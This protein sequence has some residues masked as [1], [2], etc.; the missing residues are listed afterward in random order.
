MSQAEKS[1]KPVI[2]AQIMGK[3]IGGGVESVI[4][5]YYRHLD[6]TKVQFDF[7]CDEDSTRIP[8]DEIKK[9]G[10]RVF[11]VPKYQKLPQYLKALEGL[12]RK[13]QYR[14]VHS[15]VNT[16]SVFPLYAAKKAGVPVRISHSHST[17]NPKEWKRNIIKN[18]L[19]P[20]SKKYATDYF[21]CSELAGRYLFGDKTFDQGKVKIIHNAIDL[22]KF[23]FDPEARKKLRKELG[24]DDKTIVIGHVGRFVKQKNHDFLVDVFN[25]YHT[26]NPD[27]KLLL[28]GTGPLEEKIKAKVKKLDL[29]D[30][31][32]FLGQR[33]DTNKLYSVMDVFCLPSLYEGLPVV[34]VEA[35]AAGLLCELSSDMTKETKVLNATRFISLEKPS[36][37]WAKTILEDYNS[38][39]RHDITEEIIKN[40]YNIKKEVSKLENKYNKLLKGRSMVK[41]ITITNAY[42]WYNKGDAGILLATIDTLKKIYKDAEF[43][44]LSFTPEIDRKH[45]C[46]DKTVK[47][48]YSNILNPHPYKKGKLGK[49][50][51]V[52]K[53]FSKMIE[54]QFGLT[55]FKKKTIEK[56]ES[57]KAL[58]ESDIIIVCGGGF[59]GGKKFDSLMHVYQIYV[60]TIFKKPVYIMGTSIEPIKKKLIKHYTDKV[61]N[62]VDF[63]FAREKIT[64]KYLLETLPDEKH[65]LIPDMAFMLEDI[66]RKFDF[67]EKLRKKNDVLFGITVRKWNFPNLKD[68]NK[69][70]ENYISCIKDF[71]EKEFNIRSC[72]FVFI[73]QV[74]VNTGDDT[75][76]AEEIRNRL[77]KKNQDKFYIC[78]E[79]L[80]PSEIKSL[81]ANMDYF[82]GTR[83][84]SNIFATSMCVPTTAIAYEKKTNGIMETVGLEEYIIEINDITSDDL[85]SKVE[86][87]ISNAKIIKKQL[88]NKIGAARKDVFLK[89]K[90]VVK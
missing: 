70:M 75:I 58:Q 45:Y 52:I 44:I 87:M 14:I 9:L 88:K 38:F 54:I 39:K 6:H 24:I 42:T 60:N 2:V 72:A 36:E 55:F 66:E 1:K 15:N 21:A 47:N 69:S 57:L 7:I 80:S 64:E 85:F 65:T 53:L 3:W 37:E 22:D 78:R 83:M 81:I 46:E 17:S 19:R 27:S 12:F 11:L 67:V 89:I 48:V 49:I 35:Q 4:M 79:D 82:V 41:K 26:K 29:S 25:E 33:E 43:N 31:V 34:G 71:M 63:V 20:F 8:Y 5:N 32:L 30:S 28:I 10:G 62:K 61:L 68:K 50:I 51:A 90:K 59:L 18:I 16:L 40:N 73:P 86:K 84:H 13:N 56:Y 23:K 76:I 77:S 74:T